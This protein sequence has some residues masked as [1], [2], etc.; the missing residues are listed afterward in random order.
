MEIDLRK[1]TAELVVMKGKLLEDKTLETGEEYEYMPI[2]PIANV[3]PIHNFTLREEIYLL[4]L[5][6]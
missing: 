5:L 2:D 6:L 1:P 3:E 4:Q